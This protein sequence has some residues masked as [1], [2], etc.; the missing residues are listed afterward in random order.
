MTFEKS[1]FLTQYRMRYAIYIPPNT[2]DLAINLTMVAYGNQQNA[3]AFAGANNSDLL[4]SLKHIMEA[5]L[6]GCMLFLLPPTLDLTLEPVDYSPFTLTR[7]SCQLLDRLGLSNLSKAIS[8]H[9]P[10]N[11][12][13]NQRKKSLLSLKENR[14]LRLVA[15][16]IEG[17]PIHFVANLLVVIMV[18]RAIQKQ[19]ISH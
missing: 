13:Q 1:L 9:V 8:V 17:K 11:K 12:I 14:H 4:R 19:I 16:S 2:K 5:R 18:S 3:T 7:E 6:Y 10:S 15:Y